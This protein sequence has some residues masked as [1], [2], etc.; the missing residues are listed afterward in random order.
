MCSHSMYES[1]VVNTTVVYCVMYCMVVN[2][3]QI[4]YMAI[5]QGWVGHDVTTRMV[6]H[7]LI[8]FQ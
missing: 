7:N 6:L 5:V 4:N 1:C 2:M 8:E 3:P